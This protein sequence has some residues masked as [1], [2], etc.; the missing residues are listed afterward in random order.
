MTTTDYLIDSA[1]VLLVLL[2]IK[3][4][5]LTTKDL[6]RPLVILGI[7]VVNYL[8][9]IPTAGND[10]VLVGVLAL[11]GL[12]IGVASG[13]TVRMRLGRDGTVLARARWASAF[14]WVLGMGSRF[15]FLVW[16]THGGASVVGRFSA[17][18]A[19]TSGAAWTAALLAMAVFEVCGRT[20]VLAARRHQLQQGVPAAELA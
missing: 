1:L 15:A 19:I 3:E 14:F 5:T 17:E 18:H 10:L 2:Q 11:L 13:Q 9:G 7:A 8:H 20:L 6:V 16:I 12:S 4:R